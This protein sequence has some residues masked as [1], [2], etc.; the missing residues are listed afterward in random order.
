[1]MGEL[2]IVHIPYFVNSDDMTSILTLNNNMTEE[3][4]ATVTLFNTK[5]EALVLPTIHLA[6][7]LPA[8][9]DLSQLAN[10]P[11]FESG[12]VQIAFNGMSMGIT[13]QASV[14]STARRVAFESVED[15]AMDFSSSR[16]DGILWLPDPEAQARLALTNTTA[17]PVT[18]TVSA[19]GRGQERKVTLGPH[20]TE[21]VEANSFVE[22][23]H[24]SGAPGVLVSIQHDA[25]PGAVIVTGFAVNAETAFSSNFPF[26]DRT[27][28]VSTKLAGAHV[29]AGLPNPAEGFPAGTRFS[30]PLILA[31][32]GA[33]QTQATVWLDYTT[34][35]IPHKIQVGLASLAPG[36]TR[37]FE[38]SQALATRGIGGPLDDAG[39]DV[40]YT[41]QPGTVIGRLTSFNQTGDFAFDVP[42]KDPQAGMMRVEGSYPWRLDNGTTTVVHLKNT[43]NQ[44]VEAIV[45]VRYDG[46][47][48]NPERVPLQPYQTVALDIGRMRDAQA[49]DIRGGV[50]P[51]GVLSGQV[52]WFEMTPGSLIGRAEVANIPSGIASSFSCGGSCQCSASFDTDSMSPC[53]MAGP[54]GGSGQLDVFETDIDCGGIL[55]G[56]YNRTSVATWSTSNSSVATVSSGSCTLLAPGN[57]TITASFFATVYNAGQ[58]C[59]P[60]TVNPGA[61]CSV[62][63]VSAQF[64]NS[65][66]SALPSPFRVGIS[67]VT[68]GNSDILPVRHDRTQHLRVSVTP[69]T[70]AS[71]ISITAS[72]SGG[73]VTISNVSG[74]NSTGFV[75][76]DIVGTTQSVSQGDVTL[77]ASDSGT[78]LT[79]TAAVSVIVPHNISSMHDTTGRLDIENKWL[80]DT[81]SPAI[82]GLVP[83]TV[84]LDTI[85]VR[86]LNII[87]CDQFGALIGDV[88]GNPGAEVTEQAPDGSWVT[89][90]QY[91]TTN[92]TYSDPVG[93]RVPRTPSVVAKGSSDATSWLGARLLP[94]PS[95]CP[96]FAPQNISVRVDGFDLTP[97]VVDRRL[98]L[99]GDGS[100]TGP[101]NVTITITWP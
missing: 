58:F 26:V 64:Q 41:G 24:G 85:Y 75:R 53:P 20:E 35:S 29:R 47:T 88:Y 46:G 5:G 70:E 34:D 23:A 81:T 11:D 80:D 84:E 94:Y 2:H 43:I 96:T 63:A 91:L 82:T 62:T 99:C 19:A 51:R 57:C 45:Q 8:R 36:Q 31:N 49:P 25:S 3:A 59:Q 42:I 68:L 22:S 60:I 16:L 4:A 77:T 50:M 97:S 92:S 54:V 55:Y 15:E 9:F 7:Q 52:V 72:G 44:K 67:K 28:L 18:A 71:H 76:F 6:P 10:K 98:A 79:P 100:S 86:F 40:T 65:D 39:V 61:G 21:L 1:M 101:P 33:V 37:Q 95:G 12:N 93:D 66:G 27:T 69:K 48:Y 73:V 89:I 74:D 56:P 17:S 38:L 14:I 78:P 87:V 32:A 90:N 13:S 30:A 83:H